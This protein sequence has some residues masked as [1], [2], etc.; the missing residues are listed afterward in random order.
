MQVSLIFGHVRHHQLRAQRHR[1]TQCHSRQEVNVCASRASRQASGGCW[2]SHKLSKT[3]ITRVPEAHEHT[4]VIPDIFLSRRSRRLARGMTSAEAVLSTARHGL[5][6]AH[7]ASAGGLPADGLLAPLVVA[8]LG[9]RVAARSASCR[10]SVYALA[11]CG[12]YA[13]LCCLWKARR[14]QRRHRVCVLVLGHVSTTRK[15]AS[16]P[17]H[18]AATLRRVPRKSIRTGAYRTT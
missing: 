11:S 18:C 9:V 1:E 7:A 12:V 13:L 15:R 4:E 2:P 17:G 6:V 10:A 16:A 5:Q 14:L 8:G 3:C